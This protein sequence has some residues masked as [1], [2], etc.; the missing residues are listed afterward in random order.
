MSRLSLYLFVILILC[1]CRQHLK[2]E[3]NN[4]PQGF[5]D[6]QLVGIWKITALTSNAPYDWNGDGTPEMDIYNNWSSCEKD[7]LYQFIGDK[8]GTFK[9][10]CNTTRPGNWQIHNTQQ[11]EFNPDGFATVLERFI[12][13]TS[14][15]FKTTS[16]AI[17]P[18]GQTYTLTKT[19]SRQ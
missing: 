6:S 3:A 10:N 11:L 15:E 1:S 16:T 14:V 5:A 2:I 9:L 4:L 19:W 8:T 17:V 13:M 18:S 12:S 7:N